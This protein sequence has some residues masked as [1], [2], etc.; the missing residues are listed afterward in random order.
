M[1]IMAFMFF[2]QIASV[3]IKR[4]IEVGTARLPCAVRKGHSKSLALERGHFV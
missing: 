3:E 1:S 4:P 2:V